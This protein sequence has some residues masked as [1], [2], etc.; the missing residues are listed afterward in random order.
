[1]IVVRIGVDFIE[2]LVDEKVWIMVD[3]LFFNE[4]VMIK[5][6]LE[7]D[8][9]KFSFYGCFIFMERGWVDLGI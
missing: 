4:L 1:M 8:N 2:V 5:V 9:K 7:E 3:G 6:F